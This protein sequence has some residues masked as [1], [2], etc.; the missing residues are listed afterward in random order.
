MS[1]IG[2][3]SDSSSSTTFGTNVPPVSFPGIASGID[4]N[5]IINKYTAIT[6]QQSAPLKTKVTQLSA[7]ETE[8]LKIQNLVSKLQ[9]TFSALSDPANFN[10]FTA[11]STDKTSVTPSTISGQTATPGAYQILSTQLATA[12]RISNDPA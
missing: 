3:T 7:Q 2:S 6:A 1:G 8:L 5:A 12:T 11:T 4:Y 9:D 10:A